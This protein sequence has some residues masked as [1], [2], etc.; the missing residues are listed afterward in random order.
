M[1]IDIVCSSW[2]RA[3]RG[4]PGSSMPCALRSAQHVMGLPNLAP[5]DLQKVRIGNLMYKLAL[6]I[7]HLCLK[8]GVV[9]YLENPRSSWLFKTKGFIRLVQS[10]QAHLVDGDMCQYGTA[11]K[12]PTRI[13]TNMPSIACSINKKRNGCPRDVSLM[14]GRAK[15]AATYTEAFCDSILDGIEIYYG[16]KDSLM[17]IESDDIE[18]MLNCDDM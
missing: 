16:W 17:E 9:G 6:E 2:S 11:Y 7:I 12:K 3:R 15:A 14:N 4:P 13:L 1:G 10:K 18:L 8:H 5:R